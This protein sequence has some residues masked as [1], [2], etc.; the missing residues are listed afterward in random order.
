M[1]R[2]SPAA[3]A[4]AVAAALLATALPAAGAQ[5]QRWSVRIMSNEAGFMTVAREPGGVLRSHFEFNDRG[6]GPSLDSRLT[7]AADGT[8]AAVATDGHEYLKGAVAER[9]SRTG[10]KASWKNRGEQ[11]ESASAASA[12]YVSFDSTPVELG[13]LAAAAARAPS[14][15]LALLPAGEVTAERVGE[16]EVAAAGKRRRVVQWELVGLGF[17]PSTVWLDR[18]GGFFG[19]T[20][21]WSTILPAGWEGVGP[22]LLVAQ[23]KTADA[24]QAALAHTLAH[25]PA[26]GL[27][28]TGAGLF[29]AES[30]VVRPGMTLLVVGERIAAVGADGTVAIP[31][32]AEVIDAR[33]KTLIP[34]LWD[35]HQHL[36]DL[37]GI[38]D[39]AAGVTTGRDLANDTESLLARRK[40]WADGETIGPRVELAGIIDG[41]GPY[42]G[43]TKVLVDTP[44]AAEAAVDHYAEL[45][46]QQIKIYSSVDPA[47]VPVIARRAHAHHLRVSGHVPARMIA[48]QAIADGYDEIQHANF[49]LLD[50]WPEVTETR[51]PAR[52]T[53]VAKR[54]AD[55]DLDGPAARRLID[56]MRRRDIVS[57]P[58]LGVFEGMFT[59]RAG[60][61][62]VGWQAVARRLPVQ[63]RRGL[64]AGGL[65]VPEGMD[66]R[67]RAAFQKML[68]LVAALHAAGV[69]IVAGTDALAGFSL[70]RELEL[71]VQAGIP[72]PEVLRLATLGAARVMSKD[73]ERGSL[74]PG[75]LA[76]LALVPGDPT[77]DI[78]ALRRIEMVV[79]GG[80]VYDAAALYAAIGVAPAMP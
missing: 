64:L 74:V 62:G 79:K 56:L 7:V 18:D 76:D 69:R 66:A 77:Q 57:D 52:F 67:Y 44:A 8:L 20:N 22:Q 16:I 71:Y 14:Q 21:D 60:E 15:R 53:E 5:P 47:L 33:G 59:D 75:K 24:R 58:T 42:A 46:Y 61:V 2:H 27:A 6:R 12:F 68:D 26:S 54:A 63:V 23:R 25:H 43:P 28:F 73:A 37:D 10:G 32:G 51:T 78:S 17:E 31:A 40:R 48:E 70:H 41:P 38:L 13:L 50:L 34:G 72:A 80:T 4:I 1:P 55:V 36:S 3:P 49:L 11:G 65:P 39:L 35:M 30:G 29:D 45:G 9:F 19:I